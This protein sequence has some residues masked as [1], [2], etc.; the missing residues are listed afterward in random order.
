MQT[1]WFVIRLQNESMQTVKIFK[2]L[3]ESRHEYD[4]SRR[5]QSSFVDS[6]K[7][8]YFPTKLSYP[9]AEEMIRSGSFQSISSHITV[10]NMDDSQESDSPIQ[11]R[12]L[13][14]NL[15]KASI[16]NAVTK[17]YTEHSTQL[18]GI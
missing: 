15:G 9:K 8:F 4:R 17:W 5:I 6:Q 7:F 12:K 18:L 10:S 11:S 14:I 16:Q 1:V 2:T 13:H 3:L